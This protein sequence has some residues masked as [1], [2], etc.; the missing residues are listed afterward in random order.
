M[1]L[2]REPSIVT[3]ACSSPRTPPPGN[4]RLRLLPL[5][6][7]R[8][9]TLQEAL[10]RGAFPPKGVT[11]PEL[12]YERGKNAYFG[13]ETSEIRVHPPSAVKNRYESAIRDRPEFSTDGRLRRRASAPTS[14]GRR[15]PHF[16]QT[17]AHP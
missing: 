10:P 6:S 17:A 8:S 2:E 13:D 4:R 5:C 3:S 11:K 16:A 12:R 14:F 15:L 1:E 9:A 7:W